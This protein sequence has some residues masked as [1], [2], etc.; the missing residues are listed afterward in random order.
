MNSRRFLARSA[1]VLAFLLVLAVVA[2]LFYSSLVLR[3]ERAAA[4]RAWT[5]P[6]VEITTTDHSI[7]LAPTGEASGSGLVFIPGAKVDPFAYLYKL[8]GMVERFGATV[9]ITRPTLNLALF[10]PRPLSDFTSDAPEVDTWFVG[11]HS[12]GGVRAC[13]LAAEPGVTGL[14]LFAS[15]CANDLSG[16]SLEVLS[17]SG[18]EDG[19]TTPQKIAD[20]A[21]LLPGDADFVEIEGLNH[22][23]FGDYGRQ[24]GDGKAELDSSGARA[25]ITDAL[26]RAFERT[27]EG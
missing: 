18:S 7:V 13:Q 8:T 19:L 6:A 10:D 23:G 14:V 24:P 15:Y 3:G 22:A 2:F 25:A 20:A 1:V 9:V 4:I 16:A 21:S 27:V 5:D 17:I 12:L 26:A 11:G